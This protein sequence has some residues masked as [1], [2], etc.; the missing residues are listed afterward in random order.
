LGELGRYLAQRIDAG[1]TN[2]VAS[3]LDL[4]EDTL[5]A[6]PPRA[7]HAATFGLLT[8]L[9]STMKR[10]GHDPD[11]LLNQCG[12]KTKAWWNNLDANS[13]RRFEW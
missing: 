12:P 5:Q 6:G 4:V 1:A 9:Q 2:E 7:I 11:N 10:T 13:E 3:V 8:S